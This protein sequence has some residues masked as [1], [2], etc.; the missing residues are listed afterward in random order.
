[1]PDNLASISFFF[2]NI[3]KGF[4]IP[5]F[6]LGFKSRDSTSK[7]NPRAVRVMNKMDEAR[8]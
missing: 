3:P 1:M 4:S 6:Y 5:D 8:V 7:R 2:L